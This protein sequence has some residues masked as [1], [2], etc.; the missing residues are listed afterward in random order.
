MLLRGRDTF[1]HWLPDPEP[2][3]DFDPI[4]V[5]MLERTY[6]RFRAAANEKIRAGGRS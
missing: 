4:C 3:R 1:G 2:V 5:D 6:A